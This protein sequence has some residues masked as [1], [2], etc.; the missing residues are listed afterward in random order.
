MPVEIFAL[1]NVLQ[2]VGP[3]P[4]VAY[5]GGGI[6]GSIIRGAGRFPGSSGCFSDQL[7][8]NHRSQKFSGEIVMRDAGC[9]DRDKLKLGET[10][11]AMNR[12]KLLAF[13]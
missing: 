8:P 10:E 13:A 3:V 2:L 1:A 5:K 11:F 4:D 9:L 6:K 7:P 12:S